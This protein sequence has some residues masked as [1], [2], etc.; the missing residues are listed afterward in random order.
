MKD[1]NILRQEIDEIDDQ[2]LD[3]IFKR[4]SITSEI[5]HLKAKENAPAIDKNRE[6]Q[7][8]SR[9]EEKSR[10]LSLNPDLINSIYRAILSEVVLKHNMLVKQGRNA[11]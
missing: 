9:L 10:L 5:G 3:L 8:I 7:I 1:L 2:L 4:F 6:Y 11:G